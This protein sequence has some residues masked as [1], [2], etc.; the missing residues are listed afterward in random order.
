EGETEARCT[1]LTDK[2]GQLALGA[3]CPAWFEP[4]AGGVGYYLPK[5]SPELLGKLANDGWKQ[6]SRTER[7]ALVG[8]LGIMLDGGQVELGQNLE[9][10]PRLA[11]SE[12]PYLVDHVGARLGKST[13]LVAENHRDAYAKLVRDLLGPTG[14]RL[15]WEPKPNDSVAD[16]QIRGRVMSLLA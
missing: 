12:D 2:T 11:A 7:I 4:N 8:D 14:K 1:L 10:L 3:K 9:M 15:G 13:Q 6:L 16:A 5:L